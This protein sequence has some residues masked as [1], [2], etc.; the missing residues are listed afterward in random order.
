MPSKKW[1]YETCKHAASEFSTLKDFRSKYPSAYNV[2]KKNG[3][4]S[5]YSWLKVCNNHGYWTYEKCFEE[6]RKYSTVSEF[7]DKSGSAH[8]RAKEKG[9]IKDYN[10][11]VDGKALSAQKRTIWTYDT[12]FELAKQC[13]KKSEMKERNHRAYNVARKN[14]WFSDYTWFLDD[15][16]IRHQKRPSRVK[17]PYERCKELALQFSTLVEFRKAYPSVCTVSKR[18]GW[19]DDFDW[20]DRS[21]NIYT[22]K[23]D[24][25]YAYFFHELNSVYVGRTVEPSSRDISHNTNEK[26]TVFRFAVENNVPVPKMIILESG[27][28]ITEGLDKEDFYRNKYQEEGW[29]VLN[30]AKTGRKSGS[31]GGLGSGKWNYKTCRNEA[32]KYRTLKEFRKKSPAAYNVVCK[33]GW[34]NDYGWLQVKSHKPGFWT[35]EKCFDE[36][37]KYSSRKQFQVGS[38]AAY[39]KALKAKWLDDYTWFAPSATEFRW[40][41]QKCYDEAKKYKTLAQFIKKSGG[42][43]NVARKNGWLKQ[44]DWLVKKDISKKAVLQ[45]SLDGKFI[46]RYNGVREASRANGFSNACISMCCNGK[47]NSHKGFIWR[48]EA[49]E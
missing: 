45:F 38:G 34:Q 19:L 31:L 1:T 43:Y 6:A 4:V 29:N 28:T 39:D 25:V 27:L 42:A 26:S 12:C 23:I 14:G 48:Y 7:A 3:W 21:G 17:W 2:A 35:Y 13:H 44:F 41:Y 46:A 9:W 20:L 18:N 37:K 22:S 33:H 30:V 8:F 15:D 36:A 5:E 47:L 24:N 10:W 32:Q 11:F 40:D 49:N 16:V